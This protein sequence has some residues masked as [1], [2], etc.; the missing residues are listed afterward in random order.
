[1]L[2]VSGGRLVGL[3]TPFGK[4]GWFFDEWSGTNTWERVKITAAQCPRIKP[5]FLVEE[6]LAL[7]E[8]W[9]N[10]EYFCTFEDT[11]DAVFAHADILAAITDTVKPLAVEGW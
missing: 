7:G 2:A 10:Q 11:I 1:M 8:R 6:R 4:R 3:S 9:Y 5:A